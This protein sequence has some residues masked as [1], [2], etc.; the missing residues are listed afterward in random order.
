MNEPNEPVVVEI[1]GSDEA[2]FIDA[3]R[4]VVYDES[5]APETMEYK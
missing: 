5:D 2:E 4:V 3:E 1:S